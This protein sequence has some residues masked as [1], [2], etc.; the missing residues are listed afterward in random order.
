MF[1][2]SKHLG[3]TKECRMELPVGISTLK[4]RSYNVDNDRQC[5]CIAHFSMCM[6]VFKGALHLRYD[7]NE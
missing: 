7:Y 1:S 2:S 4:R 5:F 6:D 3:C